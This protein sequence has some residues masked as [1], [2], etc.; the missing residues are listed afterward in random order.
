MAECGYE[1][2][3]EFSQAAPS[4]EQLLAVVQQILSKYATA[5][6]RPDT[7]MESSSEE[8]DLDSGKD[9]DS[10][11]DAEQHPAPQPEHVQVPPIPDGDL[12]HHNIR[13]LTCDLLYLGE[14]VRAISD[15]DIGRIEDFLP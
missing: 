11:S 12:A 9:M 8:S 13:L 4:P 7:E 5:L 1:N 14:L 15:G 6:A 10:S 3:K 2:L